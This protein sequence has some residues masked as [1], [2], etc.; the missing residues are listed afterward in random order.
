MT[1][2]TAIAHPIQGLLKYHGLR[3]AD[4]RIPLHDSISVCVAPY[5]TRTTV[6][7]RPDLEADVYE[8]DGEVVGGR[9]YERAKRVVDELRQ[10]SKRSERIYM[11]S[12]N[13]F[14]SNIGLGASS[15]GFAALA[16]AGDAAFDMSLS[17]RDLTKVARLGA[18]SACRA[19]AGYYA[20]WY[21]GETHSTSYAEAI[22]D[23]KVLPM[24]IVMAII[25]AYKTTENAHVEVLTS[26]YLPCRLAYVKAT[27][28]DMR[29]AVIGGDFSTVCLM[30]EK[31]SLSLHAVTMTG[32]SNPIYWQ[33]ET[34]AVFHAV[35][36]MRAEGLECYFSV[37]TGA[38]VYINSRPQDRDAVRA[39]IDALGIETAVGEV[40]GAARLVNEHLF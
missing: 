38:T 26:A 2:A 27:L 25:P 31:D 29:K 13:N 32:D 12:R 33:P 39:R 6:E 18:G 5:E 23:E 35:R 8:I 16:V 1:K 4:L 10:M 15:S 40:G 7:V 22:A 9:P 24:G 11:K 3:D 30:A 34:L 21:A 14:Q 28:D 37:D 20:H 19:V 17:K 36:K